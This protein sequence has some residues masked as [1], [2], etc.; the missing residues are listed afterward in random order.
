[1]P[2]APAL[3]TAVIVTVP[4]SEPPLYPAKETVILSSASTRGVSG[5]SASK[6][7]GFT[8]SIM[9]ST[10][11]YEYKRLH[12]ISTS[13]DNNLYQHLFFNPFYKRKI[14]WNIGTNSNTLST[15]LYGILFACAKSEN[16]LS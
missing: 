3:S 15:T 7:S 6:S 12:I 5:A 13:S 14:S 9:Y 2:F 10:Y 11:I 16:L 1:M 8:L 4:F